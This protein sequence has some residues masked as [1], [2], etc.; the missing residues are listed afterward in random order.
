[1]NRLGYW[2]TETG[3]YAHA[4]GYLEEGLAMRRRLFDKSNPEIASSLIHVAILQVATQQYPEALA[5]AH[6]AGEIFTAALS[7]SNWKAALAD[8]VNG[9]ALARPG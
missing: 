7:A 5:S 2:L 8:S 4:E 6:T 1:M 9:A 3:D